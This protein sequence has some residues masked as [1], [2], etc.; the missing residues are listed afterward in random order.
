MINACSNVLQDLPLLPFL[1]QAAILALLSTT[2][3]LR[4]I[5]TATIVAVTPKEGLLCSP[6]PEDLATATSIHVLAFSSQGRLLVVESEGSF[7]MDTWDSVMVKAEVIC[8]GSRPD[9]DVDVDMDSISRD[10]LEGVMRDSM[11]REIAS[12]LRWK[13]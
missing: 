4:T 10:G 6:S 11:A 7:D 3:P 8:R 12:D 1:L 2:I 13:S 5:L 9:G